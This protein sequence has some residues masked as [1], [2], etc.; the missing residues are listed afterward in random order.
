MIRAEPVDYDDIREQVRKF[1]AERYTELERT[2][3]PLVDNTFGEVQPGHLA[4]Y[5][6]TMRELGRLYQTSKPPRDLENLVPLTK[7]Q[8]VLARMTE[9]HQAELEVAVAAAE[10]R[11]RMELSSGSRVSIQAAQAAIETKLLELERRSG[12]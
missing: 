1:C 8:E 2:L 11:V 12:S 5:V 10:Q 4:G 9:Q 3:R 7:V 6:A